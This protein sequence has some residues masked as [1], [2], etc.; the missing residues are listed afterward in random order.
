MTVS[1]IVAVC[2]VAGQL[3]LAILGGYGFGVLGAT[4]QR[5]L[6]PL[7]LLGLMISTE[8]IIVP[9]YYQFR[10]LGLTNTLPGVILIQIGMGVPFG[11]FWMRSAFRS[12]PASLF[13]SA[14]AGR[15]RARCGCCGA[16]PCRWCGRRC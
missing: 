10:A 8:A 5:V 13:E 9:L 2:A 14:G 11:I 4:G 1:L 12:L 7:V 3:V 6:Y 15:R 16:S